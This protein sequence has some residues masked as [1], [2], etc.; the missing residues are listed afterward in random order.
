[1]TVST[2]RT[3]RVI[4]WYH[5]HPHITVLASHVGMYFWVDRIFLFWSYLL[6]IIECFIVEVVSAWSGNWVIL[7]TDL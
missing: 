6:L 4:G 2:G 3:T 5:S 1:M 7:C